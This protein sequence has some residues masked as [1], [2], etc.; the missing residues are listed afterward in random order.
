MP[1]ATGSGGTPP[2]LR[3]EDITAGMT[4]MQTVY[5]VALVLGLETVVDASYTVVFPPAGGASVR[6]PG[7]LGLILTSIV[8]LAIRFFW[9]P[10][11]LNSYIASFYDEWRDQ[12][13]TRITTRHFPVTLAHAFVFYYICQVFVEMT[14]AH[15][16]V[17]SDEMTGYVTRFALLY[18]G[19]LLLN[20]IWLLRITPRAAPSNYPGRIWSHNNLVFVCLALAAVAAC[21]SLDVANSIFIIVLCLTFIG[22]SLID[23]WKA[24]KFYILYEQ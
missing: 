19:L 8:L 20:G 7:Y 13:F 3:R 6:S 18:A 11:N 14:Q 2:R 1:A 21:K 4:L 9:V 10:R 22:N 15:V 16:G 23:L 5:T 12:V 24:S 17:E